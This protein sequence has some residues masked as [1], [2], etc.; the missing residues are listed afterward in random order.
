MNITGRSKKSLYG[1]FILL[2]CLTSAVVL[3][4]FIV[5]GYNLYKIQLRKEAIS[6]AD[7]VVAFRHWIANTGVVWVD[8]LH[9]DN[10]DFLSSRE[11]KSDK[12]SNKFYSKN[13]ALAT[14]ELAKI[15]AT[16]TKGTTF[17]VTSDEFR[18]PANKPDTFESKAVKTFKVKK[19]L[20]YIEG[21]DGPYYRYSQSLKV[22]QGCLKCHGDPEEAPKEVIEKYGYS[23]FNYKLGDIRGIITVSI[24]RI[25][26]VGAVKS[27]DPM[28]YI[29]FVGII[30]VMALNLLW[31]RKT[32]MKPINSIEGVIKSVQQGNYN[33]RMSVARNDEFADIAN[34]FN[35]TM[36]KISG[37]LQT[38]DERNST[39]GNIMHFLD[40]VSN[41]ADGDLRDKAPVTADVFGSIAD[42]FNLML[43]GLTDLIEKVRKS[44]ED[45]NLES[46]RMLSVLKD[47][48][49]GSQAQVN[50]VKKATISVDDAA[51][52]AI[53]I[54]EKVKTAKSVSEEALASV[55]RGS[56]TVLESIDGMQLIRVTIQAINK[57]MKYLSERL[58]E[59]NTISQLITEISNRTNLLALNASIEASRAGEQGKGF[60]IIAD[61]IKGLAERSAKSTKQISEI[62]NAIQVESAEVTKHLEE[63][64]SYVETETKMAA[65]TGTV[66]K[67]I[68]VTINSIGTIIN[69]IN[70]SAG[71]QKDIT[72]R[73]VA[74]MEDVQKVSKQML[75][76]I[77]EFSNISNSLTDTSSSLVDSVSKFKLPE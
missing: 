2:F 56:K 51:N 20:A 11:F 23:A 37:Y 66:F 70:N 32:I 63:E 39:Q 10:P 13:P 60:V 29:S 18:N 44:A 76:L 30:L 65:E 41:A 21:F 8:K 36:D 25:S 58:M 49:E 6:V 61:E 33:E 28:V 7:E 43:E 59:I 68:E 17:R 55:N 3:G 46:G 31:F 40:I 54:T 12:G 47:M 74:S 57:R 9:P 14:R 48:E 71:S 64:T 73:V 62:I 50:E 45:V 35:D 69:E 26:V 53:G 38:E 15:Y 4:A 77:Q 1:S 42:A 72:D 34:T 52:S 16:I 22:T 24:P 27:F 67:D 19:N 5:T 75:N